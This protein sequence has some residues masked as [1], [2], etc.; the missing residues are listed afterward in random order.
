MVSIRQIGLLLVAAA[1]AFGCGGPDPGGRAGSG[2][3]AGSAGAAGSGGDAGSGGEAGSG[4]GAGSGGSGSEICDPV[5]TCAAA[6]AE[7]GSVVDDCGDEVDC[8]ACVAPET[9]GDDR[10]CACTPT[11]TCETEGATCGTVV[12]DCGDEL[13]CGA[14]DAPEICGED[15][16]CACTPTVTC[17]TAGASCGSVVD[18][19]GVALDCGGCDAPETCGGA[20]A[21]NQCGCTPTTCALAGAA[22]GTIADGCGDFIECGDTCN[23][24]DVCGGAGVDNQCGCTSTATCDTL[25][26][27]CGLAP[28]ECGQL[29]FCG[30]CGYL[31]ECG[32][33]NVCE[34]LKESDE[35]LC[36][37]A[38][39]TCGPL[40]M[41]DA[42]GVERIVESC[43]KCGPGE[44]CGA[45]QLYTCGPGGTWVWE[46]PPM[47]D[48]LH[49][50]H[51]FAVD[52]VWAVGASGAIQRWD[53]SQK[54]A[55]ESPTRAGLWA[56][57][58]SPTG[59]LWVV[60]ERGTVLRQTAGGFVQVHTG[61]TDIFA[62][63]SGVDSGDLWIVGYRAGVSFMLRREGDTFN[64]YPLPMLQPLEAII[65]VHV[66]DSNLAWA[67]GSRGVILRWD[68]TAWTRQISG[69]IENLAAVWGAPDGT[70]WAAGG[71]ATL[72]F[73]G[74]A[75]V[76]ERPD[77]T[78]TLNAT[79]LTGAAD[80]TV[81][82]LLQSD[83]GEVTVARRGAGGWTLAP[84][85]MA[86][87]NLHAASDGAVWLAGNRG[88][89]GLLDGGAAPTEVVTERGLDCNVAWASGALAWA[90]CGSDL[91]QRSSG[92][93]W[94]A[95]G[96]VSTTATN[97]IWADGPD[98]IWI[99]ADSNTTQRFD[100]TGWSSAATGSP[101]NAIWGRGDT[102]WIVGDGG[103]V[104]KWSGTSWVPVGGRPATAVDYVDLVG[105]VSQEDLWIVGGNVIA[106]WDG[107]SWAEIQS[108]Y[109]LFTIHGAEDQV[110]YPFATGDGGVQK[111]SPF[112]GWE[113][114]PGF[115]SVLF[116]H[117]WIGSLTNM[118]FVDGTGAQY[119]YDGV[120]RAKAAE[121]AQG[122]RS[123]VTVGGGQA[124]SIGAGVMRRR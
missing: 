63:V 52:D 119:H 124:L 4:G 49:A 7:C 3:H 106:H 29:V 116:R 78:A 1:L 95:I 96:S 72:R 98:N 9:C 45:A 62:D 73:T 97:P 64:E 35:Q 57:W 40:Q 91:M 54:V 26:A 93:S 43:G 70:A 56:T 33:T 59:E 88:A 61:L 2:G 38:G 84:A 107:S 50:V 83:S 41:V 69:T 99:I 74:G 31:Q 85:G 90:R 34:C 53:G 21:A 117:V 92:G 122:T 87:R 82:M 67:V 20:G 100:G 18:D 12:D 39:A 66:V 14:C 24:P 46:S 17:E 89:L 23:A 28:D 27:E 81:W 68:G 111:W 55:I 112:W 77:D 19:C 22:C 121:Q 15:R 94:T 10:R 109:P 71:A 25:S 16:R 42:C 51:A 48:D 76:E 103:F 115:P 108:P 30:G 75:W 13:D 104:A 36:I 110:F 11:I 5:V 101:A 123:I 113:E 118:W 105:A 60:G 58:A 8:G 114:L 44:A 37:R 79:A 80:G 6:E 102:A 65:S 32:E 86:A 47:G 120:I